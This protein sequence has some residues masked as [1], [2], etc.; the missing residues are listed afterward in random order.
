MAIVGSFVVTTEPGYEPINAELVVCTV[1]GGV[2]G[3]AYMT[4]HTHWHEVMEPAWPLAK[5]LP[6]DPPAGPSSS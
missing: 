2:V 1:C 6:E 4:V 5:R 3:F